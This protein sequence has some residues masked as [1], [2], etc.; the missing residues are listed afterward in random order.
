MA[1]YRTDGK[2]Y[3]MFKRA[4]ISFVIA[5]LAGLPILLGI[6]PQWETGFKIACG[7]CFAF[8]VLSFLFGMF[9]EETP[10][11]VSVSQSR[12]QSFEF[13]K[14]ELMRVAP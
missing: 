4:R 5:A 11:P 1:G 8:S 12:A 13:A 10:Q 14:M 2:K 3:S 9:E 6:I 7:V